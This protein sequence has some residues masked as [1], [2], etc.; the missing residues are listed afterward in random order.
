MIKNNGNRK[1]KDPYETLEV[2]R[3]STDEEIKKS[4]R[5]LAKKYH[6]DLNP[7][8]KEAESKFK[9]ITSSYKLIENEEAR[10]KY[11]ERISEEQFAE[12][13]TRRGPFYKD[14]HGDDE[15]G[16]YSYQFD[17]N[18]EELFRSFFSGFGSGGNDIDIPGQDHLY[19][20]EINL[21]D[22]VMGA[23]KEIKL[24]DGKRIKV[25][26]PAGIGNNAKLR[27]KNQGGAG[28]GKG[29]HG[30]AYIE[31]LIR[32]SDIFKI[33]DSNLEIEIPLTLNEAVNG[34]RIKI[35][36]I[37]GSI[38][39]GIPPGINSGT[40]LRIKQK[41]MSLGKDKGRGDQIVIVKI[42]LPELMGDE[43]KEFI[44]TWSI[45]NPNNPRE[46]I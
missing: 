10:K 33:H 13:Q 28:R 41:G 37:D 16:R 29:K 7:N 3:K 31:V 6:P 2:T 21:K 30:D 15:G 8:K 14:F 34:A 45:S 40:R 23:D 44:K 36:T 38:R 11:E 42:M 43:F 35:P 24:A 20:I 27:F 19:K 26:I 12:S 4:Y 39:V 9:E 1:M 46:K 5:T 25:K 18:S 32:P 22:A 17:G